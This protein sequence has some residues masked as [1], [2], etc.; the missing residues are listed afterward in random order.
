MRNKRAWQIR[1][2]N[3]FKINSSGRHRKFECHY[4]YSYRQIMQNF[5]IKIDK[6]EIYERKIIA[7]YVLESLK[8]EGNID[9]DTQP[10]EDHDEYDES[11]MTIP[12]T[13]VMGKRY[14]IDSKGYQDPVTI[15]LIGVGLTIIGVRA[16]IYDVETGN[17]QG[18]LFPI[19]GEFYLR[20]K[21]NPVKKLSKHAQGKLHAKVWQETKFDEIL[22]EQGGW[23]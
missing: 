8:L 22:E 18:C 21:N 15:S 13:S 17:E 10:Q 4:T 11:I 5:G 6:T 2:K 19:D 1:A 23:D 20:D 3:L 7:Y 12:I 14:L 9:M 16:T